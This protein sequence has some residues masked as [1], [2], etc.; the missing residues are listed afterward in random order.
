MNR[1]NRASLAKET[2]EIVDR[3]RY[4]VHAVGRVD[5]GLGPQWHLH[6]NKR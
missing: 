4:E 3:G 1:S 2:I 6:D 5:G